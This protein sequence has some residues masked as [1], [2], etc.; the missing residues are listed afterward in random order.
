MGR[1]WDKA[2]PPVEVW[3]ECL[4][5]LKPGAFA[6]VMCIPRSDCSWRMMA[7]LEEAGFVIAFSPIVW[8]YASGF[9]KAQNLSRAIAKREGAKREGAGSEGN[10]FSLQSEYREFVL[11]E[12]AKKLAGAFAGAQMKPAYEQIIIAM[13]PLAEKTYLDQ[14]LANGHGCTWLGDCR[15]PIDKDAERR[16]DLEP[17]G[18][19]PEYE[20]KGNPDYLI[21]GKQDKYYGKSTQERFAQGRFPANLLVESDVL[22]DGRV[23]KSA[24]GLEDPSPSNAD[25]VVNFLGKRMHKTGVHHA[26]S[27]SFS[28]Y[29]SLDSWWAERV[30]KLPEHVRRV[31]PFLLIPKPS[32][33]EKNAGLKGLPKKPMKRG[34]DTEGRTPNPLMERFKTVQVHN[35]HPTCKPVKLFSYLITL[36]SRRGDLILDPFAGSGTSGCAAVLLGRDC[37]CIEL[38]AGYAEIARARISHAAQAVQ[39]ELFE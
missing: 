26:D 33:R 11:T 30:K 35:N 32:R 34:L 23:T 1:K 24:G 7:R 17:R 20:I 13:R 16:Y 22:N 6:F 29:F 38:D 15:V 19:D 4:R 21:L 28:R 37:L 9:P 27:G 2:L 5:V 18:G 3:R 8:A 31:F 14:A 12:N 36:G 10:T 39:G 25:G